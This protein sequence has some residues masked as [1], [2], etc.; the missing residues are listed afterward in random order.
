MPA[1]STEQALLGLAEL[2]SASPETAILGPLAPSCH[3]FP[4]TKYREATIVCEGPGACFASPRELAVAC[5]TGPIIAVNRAIAL[6][7]RI[8]IDVWATLDDPT[9]LWEEWHEHVHPDAKLFS[10][11]DFPNIWRWRMILGEDGAG[12]LYTRTPTYMEELKEF[13]ED[14]AA[15]MMPTLFHALAW[16]LQVGV[17]HVRLLGCDMRGSG[18]PLAESWAPEEDETFKVRWEIERKMLALSTK[19]FR[20]RGARLERWDL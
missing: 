12:R 15:P 19:E 14:G 5:L 1:R 8:P 13:S 6:G 7:D 10:G 18:S 3:D 17:R 11:N 16:C 20:K 2:R 4:E 9:A